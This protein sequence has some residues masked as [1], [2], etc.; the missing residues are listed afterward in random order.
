LFF[1][2][3]IN[4]LQNIITDPSNPILFADYTSIIITNPSTSKFEEHINNISA[5]INDWPNFLGQFCIEI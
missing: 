1:L 2:I 5:T 4:D 3:C